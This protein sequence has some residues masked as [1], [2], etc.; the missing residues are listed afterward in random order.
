MEL[1]DSSARKAHEIGDLRKGE[2]IGIML[3]NDNRRRWRKPLDLARQTRV[4]LAPGEGVI[5]ARRRIGGIVAAHQAGTVEDQAD[6]QAG[7]NGAQGLD[8]VLPFWR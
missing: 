1:R 6:R 2:A 7:G 3:P 5:S 8:R 4:G